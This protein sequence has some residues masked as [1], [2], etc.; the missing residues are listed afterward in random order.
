MFFFGEND[1]DMGCDYDKAL[2]Q[3]VFVVQNLFWVDQQGCFKG[4]CARTSSFVRQNLGLTYI[5]EQG[6][7]K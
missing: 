7:D 2:E 6:P 4:P 5:Y 1:S 3:Q